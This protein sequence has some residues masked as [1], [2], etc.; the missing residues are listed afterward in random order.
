MLG[1]ALRQQTIGRVLVII[2]AA[3]AATGAPFGLK[4]GERHR[5]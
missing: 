2:F 3:A 1:S 5:R 4:N